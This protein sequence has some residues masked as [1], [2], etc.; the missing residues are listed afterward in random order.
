MGHKGLTTAEVSRR[1]GVTDAARFYHFPTRDHLLVEALR[2]AD[3]ETED[4]LRPLA[5]A[6]ELDMTM[7][8]TFVG[9]SMD[10][11]DPI[12][13][14]A[15]LMRGHAGDPAHPAHTY[16]LEHNKLAVTRLE[17][18]LRKRLAGPR[19]D[20]G[21]ETRSTARQLLAVWTGL[22]VQWKVD[23][24]FDLEAEITQAFARLTATSGLA[25]RS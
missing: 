10:S 21:G 2:A 4:R 22:C 19:R 18:G 15:T 12:G 13:D 5:R 7:V 9:I 11:P 24:S 3:A 6:G 25:A 20:L 16:F 17:E 14:L 8:P 1:A 23:P